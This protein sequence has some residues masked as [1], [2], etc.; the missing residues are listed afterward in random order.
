MASLPAWIFA[1]IIVIGVAS[2]PFDADATFEKADLNGDGELQQ[3]E[4]STE[5]PDNMKQSVQGIFD[6]HDADYSKGLSPPEFDRAFD[7]LAWQEELKAKPTNG[8]EA[9]VETDEGNVAPTGQMDE[10]GVDPDDVFDADSAFDEAD[11]NKDGELQAPEFIGDV[12]EEEAPIAKSFFDVHDVDSSKGLSRQEFDRA[13]D[14][15]AWQDELSTGP[16]D[17]ADANSDGSVEPLELVMALSSR[18]AGNIDAA[19]LFDLHD[20][21]GSKGLDLAEFA[22]A[23]DTAEWWHA[24]KYKNYG[25]TSRWGRWGRGRGWGRRGRGWR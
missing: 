17:T 13:V 23:M 7:T 2:E 20:R 11:L 15:M 6:A 18:Q 25:K 22:Q 19:A 9:T 16:F 3:S 21:D 24:K 14:T 12:P 5:V 1:W 4:F 8:T 10:M